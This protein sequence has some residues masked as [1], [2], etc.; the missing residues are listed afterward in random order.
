VDTTAAPDIFA[1]LAPWNQ[2]VQD[3]VPELELFDAHTHIGRND[4][5]GMSQQPDE[6]LAGLQRAKARG[7]FVFPMHEPDG[8]GAANDEVIEAAHASDGLLVPFCRVNPHIDPIKEAERALERGARGIKL[9]PRAEEFTLDHP[10][11]KSLV[12]IA[13]ER[14]LPVL[15]HAGRGIPALGLHAV[16]LAGEFANARLI[17]A[18]AGICDLSWI[19]RVAPDHP[20]LLFD[21]AW[22]MP[23]DL[24]TLFSLVPPGQIVFAS[25]APYGNTLSAASIQLRWALQAGLSAEQIRSIGSEQSLR[26]AAGEPLVSAGPAAG[27]RDQAEHVLLERVAEFLLLGTIASMRGVSDAASEM[28]ALARL[29]CDVPEEI[30]D[31]PVFEAIRGL[32]DTHDQLA[33]AMP[34]DRRR[35]APL[36]LAAT[37]ART[38]DVPLPAQ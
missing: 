25:D 31:A 29:A 1:T 4:P 16:Q 18:H 5:D 22:W 27:E 24:L 30:D 35:L 32:I 26:L 33:A 23:A 14:S 12:A 34:E 2:V 10:E 9:H 11:V 36:I 15:I 13:H 21:T 37:V 3:Q 28:L 20:N 17:L 8:Y 6:L 38:P 19:W 7:A